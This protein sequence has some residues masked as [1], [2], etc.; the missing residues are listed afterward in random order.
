MTIDIHFQ[1][2][3]IVKYRTDVTFGW[4]DLMV[5]F[6]GIAGLFLGCSILSGVEIIY[7][8]IIIILNLCKKFASRA[9]KFVKAKKIQVGDSSKSR[10]SFENI[11]AIKIK[12]LSDID[13]NNIIKGSMRNNAR[14]RY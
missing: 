6:G 11:R 13:S 12:S 1:S 10:R 8:L 14:T 9:D 3:N 5:S 4:L 7:Y 2:A